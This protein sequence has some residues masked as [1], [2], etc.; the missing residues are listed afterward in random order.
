MELNASRKRR[1]QLCLSQWNRSSYFILF[2]FCIDTKQCY[3]EQMR[4]MH[5][6]KIVSS[7]ADCGVGWLRRPAH[8][9]YELRTVSS[10]NSYLVVGNLT[11]RPAANVNESII[12]VSLIITMAIIVWQLVP[13]QDPEHHKLRS[14]TKLRN[15]FIPFPGNMLIAHAHPIISYYLLRLQQFNKSLEGLWHRF[16]SHSAHGRNCRRNEIIQSGEWCRLWW[17][18]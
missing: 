3:P 2:A 4:N 11:R 12:L 8:A 14:S 18:W 10:I 16:V 13:D 15:H 9:K 17:W 7:C 6:T 1:L 5:L